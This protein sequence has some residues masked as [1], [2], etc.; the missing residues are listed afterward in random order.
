MAEHTFAF[1]SDSPAADRQLRRPDV[2]TGV[3]H[4][5]AVGK[6]APAVLIAE[7]AEI[8]RLKRKTGFGK[9]LLVFSDSESLRAHDAI[10]LH[11]P[12]LVV[13]SELFAKT[14]R[15]A[16]LIG[17]IQTDATLTHCQIRVLSD[18]GDY[19]LLVA[20]HVT[21][22]S[23]STLE[24]PGRPL[25]PQ[26]NGTRAAQRVRIGEGLEVRVDGNPVTLVDLSPTGAQVCLTAILRPYQR[27]RLVV[28]NGPSMF[29]FGASVR[30]VSFEP[31]KTKG[32]PQYR[33]G[34][35]FVDA[36]PDV[37]E[38]LCVQYRPPERPETT[39][40]GEPSRDPLEPDMRATEPLPAVV[41]V[42]N[43]E[44][45]IEVVNE[46]VNVEEEIRI[47]DVTLGEPSWH[48][49]EP[50]LSPTEQPQTVVEAGVGL[51]KSLKKS[52]K[53]RRG[54]ASLRELPSGTPV[55]IKR[56]TAK[57]K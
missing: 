20:E 3:H 31:R 39:Q 49:L 53:P 46:E 38:A 12:S 37:V 14:R 13:L 19:L 54:A 27:V 10:M 22:G 11:R 1:S 7:S 44:V 21:A 52:R 5:L 16:E 28:V 30:W 34:L 48:Q 29:R 2:D 50:D 51:K 6:R 42:V 23:S 4:E 15:G 35:G 47:E 26:Y 41:A 8:P 18:A 9:D 32:P 55:V 24:E 36:D 57:K 17:R 25:P 56:R 40:L 45:N 43:E 33:A